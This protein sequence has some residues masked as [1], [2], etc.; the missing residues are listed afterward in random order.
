MS[1]PPVPPAPPRR[2]REVITKSEDEFIRG[3]SAEMLAQPAGAVLE[4]LPWEGSAP[5]PEALPA[6]AFLGWL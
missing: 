1:V 3:A 5:D 2:K 6:S 4:S